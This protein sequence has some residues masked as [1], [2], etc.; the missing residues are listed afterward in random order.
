M[1]LTG[2]LGGA[3]YTDSLETL[4]CGADYTPTTPTA[5]PVIVKLSRDLRFDKVGLQGLHASQAVGPVDIRATGDAGAVAL[6]FASSVGYGSIVPRPA[7]TRFTPLELGID[8]KD[9][10]LQAIGASAEV[11]AQRS[12]NE[13]REASGIDQVSA[14]RTYTAILLGST[15]NLVRKGWWNAPTIAL[16]DN[17][18]TR[19]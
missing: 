5:Q 9:Y 11:V 2:C 15:P 7:D 14:S 13:L 8:E 3:A 17:D 4:A 1:V 10:G 19:E 12:W 18:P 16:V 6:V